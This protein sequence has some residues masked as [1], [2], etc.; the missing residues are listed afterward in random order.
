MEPEY[1]F[2]HP[3]VKHLSPPSRMQLLPLKSF[4][5]PSGLHPTLARELRQSKRLQKF[6]DSL[7]ESTRRHIDYTVR[8]V[9]K[10][11]IRLRRAQHAAEYL[12]E[13][14]EAELDPPPMIRAAFARNAKA[15]QG[16][17]LMP[18]SL[19]RQ[20]LI[21]IFR[22]RFPDTRSANLAFALL[23][24][25]QYAERHTESAKDPDVET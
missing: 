19:R 22:S 17:E 8:E 20:Y 25:A 24:A 2:Q 1:V 5:M 23:D 18:Q 12:M 10:E 13:A 11:D 21:A 7:P 9:K 6:F 3:P 14:M 4:S 15:R 16:W